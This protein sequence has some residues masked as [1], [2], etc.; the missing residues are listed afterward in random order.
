MSIA[1]LLEFGRAKAIACNGA[2]VNLALSPAD[3][4]AAS[5]QFDFFQVGSCTR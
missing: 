4:S 2:S 1:T 5:S 3:I